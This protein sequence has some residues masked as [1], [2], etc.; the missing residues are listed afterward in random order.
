MTIRFR[1]PFSARSLTALTACA[2]LLL[3]TSTPAAPL[4]DILT[5][6]KII[7]HDLALVPTRTTLLPKNTSLLQKINIQ[8]EKE[9]LK[10][11]LEQGQADITLLQEEISQQEQAIHNNRQQE[12]DLLAELAA[13]EQTLAEQQD[14]VTTLEEKQ[15]DQ[16]EL[17]KRKE[18]EIARISVKK[19]AVLDHLQ[20]RLKA[21]YTMDKIGAANVAFSSETFPELLS[22]HDA[23]NTLLAYDQAIITG[24]RVTISELQEAL[25]LVD[26][27]KEVLA[28]FILESHQQQ[29]EI[30]RLKEQQQ[31]L[32]SQI[33]TQTRLHQQAVQEMDRAADS[34]SASLA[35]LDQKGQLLEQGFLLNKG[36]LNPPVTGTI[37]VGFGDEKKNR[38]GI[39]AVSTGISIETGHGTTVQAIFEGQVS[40]AAYL[41]NYGNT[42]IID[43]GH[44]Y[45]SLVSRI[46]TILVKKGQQVST[47]EAIGRSGPTAT[48]MEDGLLLEIR[49]DQKPQDPL[50]WLNHKKLTRP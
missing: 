1:P 24:Y 4:I 21:Y 25:T 33:R 40:F 39:K 15:T 26:R 18:G 5:E 20:K 22:F 41:R 9:A 48:L 13:L 31:D 30:S 7:K 50:A 3:L 38:M 16:Q 6:K 47:G 32:L 35:T 28:N 8:A 44:G 14:K 27:Q 43:H 42:V 17:I 46:E 49:K 19:Q 23:F 10:H 36:L 12:R 45:S 34:L 11:D 2:W 29:D 37:L